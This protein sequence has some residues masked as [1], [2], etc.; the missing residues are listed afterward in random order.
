MQPTLVTVVLTRGDSRALQTAERAGAVLFA[1][2]LTAMAA[3]ISVPL[4]FTPVPFTFQPTIVLLAAAALGSHLG[5]A[6]RY[7]TSR[8]GSPGCPC[9]R[10]PR[11]CRS[12]RRYC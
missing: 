7:F 2:V 11:C 9:S 6:A 4:P 3:Q 12:A 5:M 8:S 1:A 10:F